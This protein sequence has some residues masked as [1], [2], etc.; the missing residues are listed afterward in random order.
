M[1]VI[2]YIVSNSL[3]VSY[4]ILNKGL[5]TILKFGF[6]FGAGAEIDYNMPS[7]GTFA[8]EIFRRDA[9]GSKTKFK[10]M[11]DAVN[12]RSRYAASWLPVDY[13]TKTSAAMGNRCLRL[14]SKIQ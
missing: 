1:H 14:L 13:K 2:H 7:G 10:T 12:S 8:L 4:L 6:L 3:N 9:S 11:R 5:V